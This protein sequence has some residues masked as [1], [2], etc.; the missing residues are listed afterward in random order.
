[1]S[2][3]SQFEKLEVKAQ[4]TA[5]YVMYQ[6]STKGKNPVLFVAAAGESN[7]E[8]FNELL[9]RTKRFTNRIQTGGVITAEGLHDNRQ[10]N[11][12][13]YPRYIVK[14][15]KN[16]FDAQD[17]PVEFNEENCVD[18]IKALPD[19]LFDEL[20]AFCQQPQNFAGAHNVDAEQLGNG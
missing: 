6:V 13:L 14:G 11:R 12:N 15:W 19:W 10:E 8:Y 3:F 20:C 5:K 16:V 7:P 4:A 1:M 2:Q 17:N 18:F 9:A